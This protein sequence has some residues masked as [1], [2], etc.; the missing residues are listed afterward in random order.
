ME[1]FAEKNSIKLDKE[2]EN[3]PERNRMRSVLKMSPF[4]TKQ[5]ELFSYYMFLTQN[6]YELETMES[7]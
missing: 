7:E 2:T 1:K 4:R 3:V 6:L 5:K